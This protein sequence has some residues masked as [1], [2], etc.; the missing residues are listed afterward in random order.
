MIDLSPYEPLYELANIRG[1]KIVTDEVDFSFFFSSKRGMSHGIRVKIIWN[2]NKIGQLSDCHS[3]TL[4]LHGDYKY[5]GAKI[6]AHQ[7]NNARKFFKK[8]KVLFAAVWEFALYPELVGDYL[9]G[10]AD[11]EEILND[12][13][14]PDDKL[15]RIIEEFH[16]KLNSA[17]YAR[18]PQDERHLRILEDIVRHQRLF[19]MND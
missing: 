5:E 1:Q 14:I 16:A 17:L 2:K 9:K 4:R 6:S 19:N 18:Y 10:H 15:G 12:L 7:L 8:Y 11:F 3:G 13:N